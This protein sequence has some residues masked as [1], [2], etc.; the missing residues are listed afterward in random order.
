MRGEALHLPITS[1]SAIKAAHELLLLP[2]T[3][4][5]GGGREHSLCHM[6]Y[7]AIAVVAPPWPP[8]SSCQTVN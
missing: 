2:L 4:K 6:H 3:D 7:A 5:Q 1:W 8:G